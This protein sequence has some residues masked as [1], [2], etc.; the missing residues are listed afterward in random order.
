MFIL[1]FLIIFASTLNASPLIHQ[2]YYDAPG[3]DLSAVFTE[4]SGPA[5][6]HLDGWTLEGI[7]GSNNQIYRSVVLDG[8]RFAPDGLLLLAT[9]QAIG[10]ILLHRDFTADVDW[11]NGPDMVRLLN[12]SGQSV[13]ALQY[14]MLFTG[15]GEGPPAPDVAAG[16]SLV[17]R[18]LGWDTHNNLLDFRINTS[19]SPT[20]GTLN[21]VAEPTTIYTA[22]L[23]FALLCLWRQ[24]F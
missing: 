11:Q 19:P 16:F 6:M 14:G 10:P 2:V 3:S 21:A 12:P 1:A 22:A 18:R 8:A 24:Y 13:D 20:Q 23:G 4:L 17:R 15:S 9:A 7:N 5:G